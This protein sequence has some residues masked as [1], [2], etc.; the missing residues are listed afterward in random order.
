MEKGVDLQDFDLENK[1]MDKENNKLMRDNVIVH[2]VF[3]AM[4]VI[5]VM[6]IFAGLYNYYSN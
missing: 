5:M 3:F 6:V 2:S 4:V 1:T